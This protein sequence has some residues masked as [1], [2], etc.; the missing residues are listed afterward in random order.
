[1]K[2]LSMIATMLLVGCTT[3]P[4]F[5]IEV[6]NYQLKQNVFLL[7]H[8]FEGKWECDY[9]SSKAAF[10]KEAEAVCSEDYYFSSPKVTDSETKEWANDLL[11][12][13]VAQCSIDKV[14]GCF[15]EVTCR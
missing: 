10:R 3:T 4:S 5:Q 12:R 8:A 13:S 14:C 7:V 2:Y 15:V 1:M 9:N 6:D 11:R